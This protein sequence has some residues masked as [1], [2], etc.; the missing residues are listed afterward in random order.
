MPAEAIV[1]RRLTKDNAAE[2][3]QNWLYDFV[4]VRLSFDE[5]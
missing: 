1:I 4:D 5:G 3:K 2:R